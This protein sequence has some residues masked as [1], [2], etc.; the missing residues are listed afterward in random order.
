[1]GSKV[2]RGK[3]LREWGPSDIRGLSS[4]GRIRRY[5]EIR[6]RGH[7]GWC[8]GKGGLQRVVVNLPRGLLA[9]GQLVTAAI[10]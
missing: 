3:G 8:G 9:R 4:V 10:L 1:M 2:G 6:G 7:A 5:C